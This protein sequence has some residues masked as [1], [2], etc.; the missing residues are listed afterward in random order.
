LL[1]VWEKFDADFDT[2]P[3]SFLGDGGCQWASVSASG[4]QSVVFVGHLRRAGNPELTADIPSVSYEFGS[5]Q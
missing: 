5:Q 2:I 1:S 4:C 3:G